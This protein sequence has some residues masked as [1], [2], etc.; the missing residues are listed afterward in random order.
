MSSWT[1]EGQPR[2]SHYRHGVS[3]MPPRGCNDIGTGPRRR[4]GRRP[5]GRCCP[6][7]AAGRRSWASRSGAGAGCAP[8]AP[9]ARGHRRRR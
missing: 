3:T 9:G 4:A 5:S 6:G 8:C 2:G 1:C 7:D